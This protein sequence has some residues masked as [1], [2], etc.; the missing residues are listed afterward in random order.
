MQAVSAVSVVQPKRPSG[1][2]WARLPDPPYAVSL[3]YP[4]ER[5]VHESGVQCFSAVEVAK[6]DDGIDRGPEYHLS[7]SMF[8]PHGAVRVRRQDAKW[9]LRAFGL[10]DAEED[11]HVPGGIARNWWRPVADRLSGLECKCKDSEPAI[12]E[13]K[14]DYVWRAAPGGSL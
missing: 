3:G 8:T 11:N 6:D 14:G 2:G 12:R 9:V 10:E 1:K 7:M 13:D 5:W 4:C